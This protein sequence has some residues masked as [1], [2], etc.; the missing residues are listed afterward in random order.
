MRTAAGRAA[1]ATSL[2][3]NHPY[4][5]QAVICTPLCTLAHAAMVASGG[6]L[7]RGWAGQRAAA[8]WQA[9]RATLLLAPQL[10]LLGFP[11]RVGP[12]AVTKKGF[13]KTPAGLAGPLQVRGPCRPAPQAVCSPDLETSRPAPAPRLEAH[14][15][16]LRRC[17][18][19]DALRTSRKGFTRSNF[20]GFRARRPSRSL[21]RCPRT[22]RV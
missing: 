19:K 11:T 5:S 15:L 13:C 20:A 22:W 3:Q 14:Q 9:A 16:G 4:H 8:A 18:L 7:G 1:E 21:K 2:A 6:G 10:P 17:R 12:I